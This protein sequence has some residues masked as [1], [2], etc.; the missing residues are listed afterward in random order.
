MGAGTIKSIKLV[1]FFQLMDLTSGH[2]LG[3]HVLYS[4]VQV[5][6]HEASKICFLDIFV[7]NQMVIKAN[8]NFLVYIL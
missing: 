3:E 8:L 2:L 5:G 1:K 4:L 7:K 6:P